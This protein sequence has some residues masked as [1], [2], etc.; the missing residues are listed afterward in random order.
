LSTEVLDRSGQDVDARVGIF[1]PIDRQ[2][3]NAKPCAL[4]SYEELGVEEPV[5]VL[6][7]GDERS[8][9]VRPHGLES[10]L[11]VFEANAQDDTK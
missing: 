3:V 1:N 6:H 7:L 5:A 9:Y 10:A 8:G 2:L 4:S 11:N